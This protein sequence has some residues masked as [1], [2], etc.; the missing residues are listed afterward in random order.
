MN[1][2]DL[3]LFKA[4]TSGKISAQEYRLKSSK[5]FEKWQKRRDKHFGVVNVPLPTGENVKASIQSMVE[6]ITEQRERVPNMPRV[7]KEGLYKNFRG[8]DYL[9]TFEGILYSLLPSGQ[10][11]LLP[12]G[13]RRQHILKAFFNDHLRH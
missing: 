8:I 13:K 4:Y 2:T 10:R 11:Q 6:A 7:A 5:R 3:N 9:L 12:N 1:K